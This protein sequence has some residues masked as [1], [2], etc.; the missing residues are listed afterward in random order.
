MALKD[1]TFF[2]D[3]NGKQVEM[4]YDQFRAYLLDGTNLSAL[5]P[6]LVTKKG[7][8]V[9]FERAEAAP[10]RAEA[11]T[12]KGEAKAQKGEA[13]ARKGEAAPEKGEAPTTQRGK[14]EVV[15]AAPAEA[16]KIEASVGKQ[17]M[18]AQGF[19]PD[20]REFLIEKTREVYQEAQKPSAPERFVIKV[21]GD[22]QFT[23]KQ[24]VDANG[25]HRRL[26]GKDVP[27]VAS[28]DKGQSDTL[29]TR[30]A[31][32]LGA[33]GEAYSKLFAPFKTGF[34]GL[35]SGWLKKDA[36]KE[37]AAAP[38]TPANLL[39]APETAL[40]PLAQHRAEVGFENTSPDKEFIT[41]GFVL[42]LTSAVKGN[43]AEKIK[44][45]GDDVRRPE[46]S[47]VRQVW[48]S[49]VNNATVPAKIA[50]VWQSSTSEGLALIDTPNGFITLSRSA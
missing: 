40:Y 46:A 42:V 45:A 44:P 31:K 23:I 9:G 49:S 38:K 20:Q 48:T 10:A 16:E 36:I 7:T 39:P 8:K 35:V 50:G 47:K 18:D 4:D 14:V 32:N 12:A 21:P 43:K 5:A 2:V 26:T 24:P 19:T 1:C 28:K 15:T 11:P 3:V 30:K 34:T 17:K 22:G 13:K 37:S 33:R 27:G 6:T 29:K 41:D 25:L